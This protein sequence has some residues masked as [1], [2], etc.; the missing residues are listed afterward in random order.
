MSVVSHTGNKHV[1][2][3]R[4]TKACERSGV[5]KEVDSRLCFVSTFR[6]T[7]TGSNVDKPAF[8]YCEAYI[9][10]IQQIIY[11]FQY[12]LL[13]NTI[14]YRKDLFFFYFISRFAYCITELFIVCLN[15]L[16]MVWSL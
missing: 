5:I 15:V 10:L 12:T 3:I 1:E 7:Y 4:L 11:I 6:H 16:L 8:F 2:L 13:E 9:F 14:H